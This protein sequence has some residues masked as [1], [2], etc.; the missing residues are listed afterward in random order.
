MLM[1]LGVQHLLD[2]RMHGRRLHHELR[3]S[4]VSCLRRHVYDRLVLPALLVVGMLRVL[5]LPVA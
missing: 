1:Q 4:N 2:L 3:L 5:Q